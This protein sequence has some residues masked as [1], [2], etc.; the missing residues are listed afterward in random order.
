[1]EIC[2]AEEHIRN[3]SMQDWQKLW[4]DFVREFDKIEQTDENGKVYS[5]KMNVA[6]SI[7]TVWLRYE[8]YSGIS[9]LYAAVY[10]KDRYGITNNDHNIHIRN[11]MRR[12]L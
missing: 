2:Q 12:R 9:H 8:S 3:F 6:N 4:N 11:R 10:R 7:Y 1:M 5:H